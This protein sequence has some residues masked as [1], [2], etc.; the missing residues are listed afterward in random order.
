[1]RVILIRHGESK[2]NISEIIGGIGDG[3]TV[4]GFL[5]A[6]RVGAYLGQKTPPIEHLLF[7][8][9][10]Q[11]RQTAILIG[12]KLHKVK[13]Y[14]SP[15]L[16]PISLGEISGLKTDEARIKYPLAMDTLG[17]WNRRDVEI[18]DV[19]IPGMQSISGFFCQGLQLLQHANRSHVKTICIIAT[20]SSL[21]LL[22]N[23]KLR[24]TPEKG[25]NYFNSH[26]NYTK[27][28]SFRL[29]IQD[30]QWIKN[31]LHARL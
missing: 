28:T 17:R 14:G 6:K 18:S 27:P 19:A 31:Q 25:G 21:V 30:L 4:K 3:L 12:S 20:R 29:T 8:P 26:F 13:M 15:F 9:T 23:I 16:K 24:C 7:A 1:M 11:T 10:V 22:R 5:A 2:K